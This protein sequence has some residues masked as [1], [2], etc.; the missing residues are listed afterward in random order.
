[1]LLPL[2]AIA[3]VFLGVWVLAVAIEFRLHPLRKRKQNS[4]IALPESGFSLISLIL[5][6]FTPTPLIRP[7]NAWRLESEFHRG[8]D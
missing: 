7:S 3:T 4:A 2:A 6:L 5:F 8:T 1:M